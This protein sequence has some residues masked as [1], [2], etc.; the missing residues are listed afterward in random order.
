MSSPCWNVVCHRCGK[1]SF[2]H[3]MSMF[4]EELICTDCQKL[5]TEH[6]DYEHARAEEVKALVA[7]NFNFPGI[8][9]P[10]DL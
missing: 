5:E 10:A 3:I 2:S 4:N 8:G 7:G 1:L 6:P 9:K